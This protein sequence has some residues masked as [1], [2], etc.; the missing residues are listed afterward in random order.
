MTA[1]KTF[2]ATFAPVLI[3]AC[4]VW[5]YGEDEPRAG[6]PD[7]EGARQDE[8]KAGKTPVRTRIGVHNGF[9][10]AAA[11]ELGVETVRFIL[12]DHQI[13]ECL[14]K[15]NGDFGR[16]IDEFKKHGVELVA[17]IRWPADTRS[18][19]E[20]IEQGRRRQDSHPDRIPLGR[21][22][23]DALDLLEKFLTA[24]DGRLDWYQI[25]NEPLGGPGRYSREELKSGAAFE[26][27]EAL[28]ER[29]RKTIASNGL[30]L[31]I[32]SPGLTGK[33]GADAA[34]EYLDAVDRLITLTGKYCDAFDI[35]LHVESYDDLTRRVT[36][37]KERMRR[38]G[39]DRP[40]VALEWSNS[41]ALKVFARNE[42][43]K[44]AE[45]RKVIAAAYAHPSSPAT[46]RRFMETLPL[47]KDFLRKSY[48]YMAGEGFLI[49]CWAPMFQYGSEVYDAV[50]LIANKTAAGR[51][52]PNEPLY[53]EFRAA[54]EQIRASR[55]DR[56]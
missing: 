56:R 2:A 37:L 5:C 29:A 14:K 31:R 26:W 4:A 43:G 19:N 15:P 33:P 23:E 44:A 30:K 50:A 6:D 20:M 22:R 54:A 55:S 35:H 36:A 41:H 32:I 42:P 16:K 3:V 51:H 10:P 46:W 45:M 17:C 8:T 18:A 1:K 24:F 40:L 21:E 53:A 39:V 48:T 7:R 25:Q 49:T 27:M 13:R 12:K 11:R 28:A 9:N 47:E 34:P 52:V 38:A